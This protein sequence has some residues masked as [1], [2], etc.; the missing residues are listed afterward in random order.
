MKRQVIG[1][2]SEIPFTSIPRSVDDGFQAQEKI[3][4][5]GNQKI[6]EHYHV[7]R[8]CLER[9]L[10]DPLCDVLLMLVL[11]FSESSVTPTVAA[12][13]QHFEAGARKDPTR[14]AARWSTKLTGSGDDWTKMHL[15][16]RSVGPCSPGVVMPANSVC[17]IGGIDDR[18]K[19]QQCHRIASYACPHSALLRPAG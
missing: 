16:E 2:G 3:L 19:A 7:A 5:M 8:N 14:F 11:A 15:M 4:A 1:F 9:S 17:L 6:L 12:K 18:Y 13:S 10:G